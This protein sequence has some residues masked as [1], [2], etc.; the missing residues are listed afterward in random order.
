[1]KLSSRLYRIAEVQIPVQGE[2]WWC[3]YGDG[4]G[5]GIVKYIRFPSWSLQRL[6]K[7]MLL[8]EVRSGVQ[9]RKRTTAAGYWKYLE[10]LWTAN[11]CR[12]LRGILFTQVNVRKAE[13]EPWNRSVCTW[14][15][16]L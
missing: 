15:V 1:M 14:N 5:G 10:S 11:S 9:K 12:L 2:L 13:R 3:C 8:V 7:G 6:E 16:V 4:D